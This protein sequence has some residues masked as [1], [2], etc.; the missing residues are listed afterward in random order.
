MVDVGKYTIHGSYGYGDDIGSSIMDVSKAIS[1]PNYTNASDTWWIAPFSFFYVTI[2]DEGCRDLQFPKV[3]MVNSS[4]MR[5]HGCRLTIG[6]SCLLN[7][8][9]MKRVDMTAA[10]T[11][12][13]CECQSLCE[14]LL[15]GQSRDWN[16]ILLETKKVKQFWWL[17]CQFGIK[18][19]TDPEKNVECSSHLWVNCRV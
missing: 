14:H 6:C 8:E 18:W 15:P 19:N 5:I 17:T 13:P 16:Q 4:L 9:S 1:W 12:V 10:W 3:S 2:W 7:R 11:M